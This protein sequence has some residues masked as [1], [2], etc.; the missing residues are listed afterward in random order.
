MTQPT[1]LTAAQQFA[2]TSRYAEIDKQGLTPEQ[3][4]FA[5]ECALADVLGRRTAIWILNHDVR[6]NRGIV[7]KAIATV[8][9]RP[10]QCTAPHF[11]DYSPAGSEGSCSGDPAYRADVTDSECRAINVEI[12]RLGGWADCY[13]D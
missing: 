13:H 1:K 11:L 2:L 8:L 3:V 7:S 4:Q 10:K 6:R 12:D 9:G 5:R